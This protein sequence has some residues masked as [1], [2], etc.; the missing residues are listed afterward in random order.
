MGG[1]GSTDSLVS[2]TSASAH[3][4]QTR[5]ASLDTR[6]SKDTS[7]TESAFAEV[8]VND[9]CRR[10]ASTVSPATPVAS[11]RSRSPEPTNLLARSVLDV[12]AAT[13]AYSPPT[14]LVRTLA[15]SSTKSFSWIHP[16]RQSDA[17]HASTGLSHLSTPV[18]SVED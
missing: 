13:C 9:Q 14:G 15:T 18:E 16:T 8:V 12:S 5:P 17:T 3:H 7:S 10:D 4:A 6:E 2:S 11:E 1:H